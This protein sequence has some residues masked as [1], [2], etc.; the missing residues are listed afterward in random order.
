MTII[1]IQEAEGLD[2]S[3]SNKTVLGICTSMKPAKGLTTPSASRNLLTLALD[4]LDKVYPS[5]CSLDLRDNNFPS[6]D[7]RFAS[8]VANNSIHLTIK[9]INR[10]GG[11][12][13]SVPAYWGGVSGV[14]K[15]FVDV[16]CGPVYDM[17]DN[18]PIQ[19]PFSNKPIALLVV[20]ADSESTN[21]GTEQAKTIL[22]STGAVL[23]G[24]VSFSNPRLGVTQKKVSELIALV[25]ELAKYICLHNPH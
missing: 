11:L 24:S 21:V 20:G 7:G 9:A 17:D 12:L 1:K 3:I 23:V 22:I 8:E 10:S 14:F 18:Q 6:F 15:N 2:S 4:S 19:T 16:L 13:L 5:V 25:A